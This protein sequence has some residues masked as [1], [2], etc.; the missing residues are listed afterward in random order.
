MR[1]W[2]NKAKAMVGSEVGRANVVHI[3]EDERDG[4]RMTMLIK[5]A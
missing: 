4:D 2:V 1:V 3:I 5:K